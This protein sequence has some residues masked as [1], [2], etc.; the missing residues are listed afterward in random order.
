MDDNLLKA[1]GSIRHY[2]ENVTNDEELTPT[3]ENVVVIT[4]LRLVHPD[5]PALIKQRYGTEL[6]SQTLASLKP[7]ISQALESL[8]EEIQSTNESKVLR[9]A[10]Q[11]SSSLRNLPQPLLNQTTNDPPAVVGISFAADVLRRSKQFIL[12]LR[13]T[14]ISFTSACI[15]PDEKTATLRD[16]LSTLFVAFHSPDGPPATIRVD[17][18]PGF[19]ALKNDPALLTLGITL[20]IGRPKN[21]NKNP[22]AEKSRKNS[23]DKHQMGNLLL[24]L[25]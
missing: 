8:L 5:L 24:N 23:A 12:V 1:N 3:L 11:Q 14:S 10:F 4:W 17:P 6:R 18:A 9:T 15:I 25:D 13:D 22:V 7:E 19:R 20:E 16:N 2:G 21:I